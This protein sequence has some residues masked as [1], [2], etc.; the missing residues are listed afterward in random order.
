MV[1]P[2]E[3]IPPRSDPEY[4]RPPDE[5]YVEGDDV[6]FRRRQVINHVV[7]QRLV[8]RITGRGEAQATLYGV[9]PRVRYFAGTLSN[10]YEYREAQREDDDETEV[11]DGEEDVDDDEPETAGG[12]ISRNVSPFTTGLKLKLNPETLDGPLRLIPDAKLFYRRLPTLSEQREHSDLTIASMDEPGVPDQEPELQAD[13]G[14]VAEIPDEPQPLVSVHERIEPDYDM[15]EVT[16][17]ELRTAA[18]R[19]EEITRSLRAPFDEAEATYRED[20]LAAR[21]PRED[22]SYH[23]KK[24]V[25]PSAMESEAAFEG[26]LDEVFTDE[27][28]DPLWEAELRLEA[29]WRDDG[30]Y[31]VT[32]RLINTHGEDPDTATEADEA[33][34]TY[35]F[36][37]SVSVAAD[38]PAFL[39]FE[40]RKI[41]DRYQYD[42]NIYGIGRNCSA[43]V[44]DGSPVTRIG[45][46]P[47]PV[48]RQPKYVSRDTIPAPFNELAE[49]DIESV[50][51]GIEREMERAEEQYKSVRDD[52]L[53]GKSS[54]AEDEFK[55]TLAQFDRE[56][57]RFSRGK[58][59]LLDDEHEDLEV[60]FRALNRTFSSMGEEFTDWRVFQIVFI[61]MSVPDIASQAGQ[62]PEIVDSLDTCDIIFFPTGGGKTEAYLGLVVFTAFL[63]RLRGKEYG[64]TA[65]TKFPLRLLSLQQ[66][67]RIADVLCLAEEVRRD[68]DRMGGEEFSVGYFVGNRNTPNNIFEDGGDT[69]NV[70]LAAEDDEKANEWLTVP[71]CPYCGRESVEVT[72]D[73]DRLRIVHQCTNPDCREVKRQNGDTAELPIYITDTEIYRYAPTFVISTIDKIAVVGMNRRARGLFGQMKRRCPE[74]GYSP[75]EDCLLNGYGIPTE[76]R[77][78]VAQSDDLQTVTPT[79]PPS[80]LIQDELH[81]LREEFG[82]FDSHYETFIQKLIR[83]YT[84]GEWEMKV[85][86]AT[87]TIEGADDQVEALYRREPNE[88]PSQGARLRQS[89]YAYEDP[90]RLGRQMVGALPRSIGRTR[91][92]NIVIREYARILQRYEA[93]IDELVVDLQEAAGD[94]VRGPLNLPEEADERQSVLEAALEDYETQICYNI[95][96][97]QSDILQRSVKGM[98]NRQLDAYGDP[99]SRLTPVSLTGET[100]M[101]EVRGALS[102]LEA[103]DPADPIDIVI[104]TSMIS[105]GVDVNQFN[106]ISFFGMPRNTAEYIQAYSRVGRKY[107][108][109]VFLL[110]DS[111]RARDRS[112][113]SRFEHYH[114]YQDLLVEATP[115]ERWA[116]FA[117][118]CTL[119]GIVLG[120]LI[121]YYDMQ[122][123]NSFEKRIYNLDGFREAVNEGAISK[124]ELLEFVYDAYDVGD[125]DDDVNSDIGARLYR[126]SIEA[127]FESLWQY[128]FEVDVDINDPREEGLKKFLGNVMEDEDRGFRAP[129]RSLRD[130]DEQIPV[131]Y[132]FET[133]L[134][135]DKFTEGT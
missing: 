110:F 69:N 13:G 10:Q 24:N 115:L 90:Y 117:I 99:H 120:I 94:T 62:A 87:A 25:P 80:I 52:V 86:A 28:R 45:T 1:E 95:S 63:D 6:D 89:F 74:H 35:L 9:D 59:L 103:D 77:C 27:R 53:A 113:Y 48:Y 2:F 84:D 85:V 133:Q 64:T 44:E 109:S 101:E 107:T 32:V 50:L 41:E 119:P 97:N 16:E 37:A 58:R 106:F 112:H 21:E 82:A 108:G 122:Y 105:H 134:L 132:D 8:D 104:A 55:R 76:H 78:E 3:S 118:E 29:D 5:R 19:G 91:A 81:L 26:H 130:V 116:D 67:Q 93:N 7:T 131:V 129:M 40:S 22:A 121:Q 83:E 126:E 15:F 51:E 57:E 70:A 60:A 56:R 114:R 68:H 71:E 39:P 61:V 125:V 34:Q 100:D 124:E 12:M 18:D 98:V 66:L 65:L 79:D 14:S 135:L 46:E 33:W 30:T 4:T 31:D 127:R 42:G 23:D 73:L 88:F 102:R 20:Q 123:E 36:D 49:G 92:I 43:Q 47:V 111:I 128:L 96:K 72:G 54:D 11:R 38:E 17:A 75:E